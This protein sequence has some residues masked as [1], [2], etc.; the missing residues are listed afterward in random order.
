MAKLEK[1]VRSCNT[2]NDLFN[3]LCVSNKT[4]DLNTYVF[5]MITRKMN[6]KFNKRYIMRM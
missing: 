2:L 4:E 6:Q 1:C 5:N 3:K